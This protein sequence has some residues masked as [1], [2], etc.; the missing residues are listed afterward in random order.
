[1]KK[2]LPPT[3]G[4]SGFKG[5]GKTTLIKEL[6]GVLTGKGLRVA[7]IKHQREPVRADQ[8]GTDT[9]RFYQAGADVVA[10]DGESVFTRTRP[11]EPFSLDLA[12]ARLD[13]GYDLVLV[14]GFK[15]SSIDKIWLLRPGSEQSEQA[16]S[17]IIEIL[18]WCDDRLEQALMAL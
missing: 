6:L 8:P 16:I 5:S 7:V 13:E 9:W 18:P 4:I 3:I 14:E 12:L 11:Q 10:W 17:N 15:D 1:M 2:V